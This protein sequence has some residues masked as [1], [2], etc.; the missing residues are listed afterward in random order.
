MLKKILFFEEKT[1]QNWLPNPYR[2]TNRTVLISSG[3]LQKIKNI[4]LGDLEKVNFSDY[5]YHK[6]FQS[7]KSS[8][9]QS[10][11]NICFV[12]EKQQL[13]SFPKI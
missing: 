11:K 9:E 12:R 10:K 3:L 2:Q 4:L 5:F 8:T 7:L 6:D 13:L 1:K